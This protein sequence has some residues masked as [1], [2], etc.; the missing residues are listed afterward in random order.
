MGTLSGIIKSLTGNY[1]GNR[2]LLSIRKEE[3]E[4]KNIKFTHLTLINAT[5]N[6]KL[7]NKVQ[8]IASHFHQFR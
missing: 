4:I 7:T 6:V 3:L 1:F 2:T 5:A 8:W